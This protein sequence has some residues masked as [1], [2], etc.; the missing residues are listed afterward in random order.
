VEGVITF[1]LQAIAVA[2]KEAGG[3]GSGGGGDAILGRSA[4]SH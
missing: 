4:K 1:L 3:G 2:A